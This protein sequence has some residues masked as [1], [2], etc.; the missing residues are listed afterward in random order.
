[1][2]KEI[3]STN[4]FW[5]LKTWNSQIFG[6]L[7]GNIEHQRPEIQRLDI[8]DEAFGLDHQEVIRRNEAAAI[9]LRDLKKKDSLQKQKACLTWI[10]DGD[11]NSRIFHQVI[12]KRRKR[13]EIVGIKL[14][15]D[16]VEEVRGVKGILNFFRTTSKASNLHDRHLEQI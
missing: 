4:D 13:N 5:E 12:N 14:N 2:W 16:W 6:N 11:I 1:M 10:K 9:L 15:G 7:E 3:L 8:I